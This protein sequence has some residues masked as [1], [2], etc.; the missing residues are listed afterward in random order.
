[1]GVVGHTASKNYIDFKAQFKK[2]LCYQESSQYKAQRPVEKS[3]RHIIYLHFGAVSH[4]HIL[5]YI[6]NRLKIIVIN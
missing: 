4:R 5:Q 2:E 6:I 3:G 1:M